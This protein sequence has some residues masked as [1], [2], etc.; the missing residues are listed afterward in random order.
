V[1]RLRIASKL[2]RGFSCGYGSGGIRECVD[3]K[4]A[5][6]PTHQYNRLSNHSKV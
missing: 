2:W 6:I 5:D 3:P 1:L 4:H